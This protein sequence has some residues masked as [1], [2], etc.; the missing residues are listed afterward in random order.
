MAHFTYI[1]V[2]AGPAGLQM[3]YFLRRRK[4]NFVI[5]ERSEQAGSFFARYPRHRKLLSINKVYTGYTDLDSRLRYDWN[6]LLSDHAELEMRHYSQAYFP[7]ADDL[8]CYL[9]DYA[10]V[11]QLP[12]HYQM[13]VT[14]VTKVSGHFQVTTATGTVSTCERLIVATGLFTP[15]MPKIEGIEWCENYAECSI[16][17]DDFKD[18]TVMIVGKGHSAFETADNLL[19]S[20]RKIQICGPHAVKLAWA[21]HYAGDLRAVNNN[22]LDTYQLKGQNNIL[23]GELRRVS[24]HANRQLDAEVYFASRQRSYT[25]PCDRVIICAGFRFDDS[26]FS[27]ECRP[28]LVHHDKLPALTSAWESVNVKNLYFIGT[29]M[30]SRDF[31]TTM[32]TFIHGF[33]HN[34]EAFDQM[35][36]RTYE[37]QPWR[38]ATQLSLDADALADMVIRRV[39]TAPGLFLQPGFLCDVVTVADDDPEVT[40]YEDM[41]V[42]YAHDQDYGRHR[43]YYVITLEYGKTT[44]YHDPFAMPLAA[45][46]VTGRWSAFFCLTIST[47]IGARQ[48]MCR[49]YKPTLTDSSLPCGAQTQHLSA[50]QDT[51]GFTATRPREPWPPEGRR[52]RSPR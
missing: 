5:L 9:D 33:R 14:E 34:I 41:P 21:S 51:A 6:S 39:S 37:G 38:R 23:D 3:G 22:F 50:L 7:S 13:E 31:K 17:P 52:S 16:N 49:C 11:L 20:A 47:T 46:M 12:I 8:E 43:H 26:I 4:A 19:E 30:S 18:Q 2:G 42:D 10:R 44:G 28:A 35:L 15:I 45:M 27:P 48:N 32:S 40:Y 24:R 1:V 25:F 29:L 36:V